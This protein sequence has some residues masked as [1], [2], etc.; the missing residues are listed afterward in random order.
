M[1]ILGHALWPFFALP[2]FFHLESRRKAGLVLS[3]AVFHITTPKLVGV[4]TCLGLCAGLV[5]GSVLDG[6]GGSV[7]VI[8]S[9]PSAPSRP[10][11]LLL[12]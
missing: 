12:P 4:R 7:L 3:G 1:G 11:P 6:G 8:P 2:S 5:L 10:P 9:A